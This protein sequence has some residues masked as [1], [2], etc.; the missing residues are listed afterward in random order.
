MLSP[1]WCDQETG[2]GVDGCAEIGEK[3]FG[4]APASL[5]PLVRSAFGEGPRTAGNGTDKTGDLWKAG[6]EGLSTACYA[7]ASGIAQTGPPRVQRY[8]L[9]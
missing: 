7:D 1:F 9:P 8:G 3:G 5:Y 2:R 6:A 4:V